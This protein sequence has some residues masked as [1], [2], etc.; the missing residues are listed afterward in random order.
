MTT[1]QLR[2]FVA[3]AEREHVTQAAAVVNVSQPALSRA[4]RRLEAELGGEL[5]RRDGGALRLTAAGRG[6]LV[7]AQRALAEL[8]AGRRRLDDALS[9]DRGEI[10]LAFLHTL[11]A[12]LVPRLVGA[13]REARPLVGYRLEQRSAGAMHEALL[14]GAVD[15]ALTSPRPDDEDIAFAPLVTEPLWLALPPGHRLAGRR[16]VRL[17]EVAGD[18]FVAVR[19]GYGLRSTTDE[20]CRRAGFTPRIAFE[21]EDVETL[22]GL[23]SAGLGVALLPLSRT[24]APH[25]PHVRVADRDCSR[26]IGLAWHG[27]RDLLPAARAFRDFVHE[28]GP[29]LAADR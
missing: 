4:L 25:A 8:D 9:P 22:R 26:T 16:R 1:E 13:Y 20:L 6:F 28:T 18:P 14:E 2:Y 12:W 15:L 24:G 29:G 17:A 11:G 7:H 3:V 27:R 21:G 5:F 19:Q 23:V 10:R